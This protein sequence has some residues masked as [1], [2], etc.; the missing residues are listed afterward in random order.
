MGI[1]STPP[2]I[3][4]V[5]PWKEPEVVPFK[6][7]LPSNFWLLSLIHIL[8]LFT[9]SSKAMYFDNK[10]MTKFVSVANNKG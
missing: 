6:V 10:N 3:K 5:Q 9:L 8:Y 1:L 7:S 2:K 4:K